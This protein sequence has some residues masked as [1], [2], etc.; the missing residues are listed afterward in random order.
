M[1]APFSECWR[2]KNAKRSRRIS[3]NEEAALL[4]AAQ[5]IKRS[6]VWLYGLIVAAIETGCRLG[7]LLALRWADVDLEHQELRIRSGTAKDEELRRLPISARTG[8]GARYGE[9]RSGWPTISACRAR[10]RQT[11]SAGSED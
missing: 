7:E 4:K 1:R 11:R 8:S 5:A 2:S 6:S 10:L 3:P 9:A